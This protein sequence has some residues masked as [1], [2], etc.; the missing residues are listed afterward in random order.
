M[1]VT[2][3][4]GTPAGPDRYLRCRELHGQRHIGVGEDNADGDGQAAERDDYRLEP[5][6]FGR[7]RKE[8]GF[9]C[10]TID[11]GHNRLPK[12]NPDGGKDNGRWVR[13]SV[14]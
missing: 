8:T 1:M 7:A 9:V 2:I 14:T 13:P 5:P 3:V 6:R 4:V 12:T 10:D 11:L